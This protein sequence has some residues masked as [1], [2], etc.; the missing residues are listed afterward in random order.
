M[1]HLSVELD[2][3]AELEGIA[4]KG[5]QMTGVKYPH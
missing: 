5:C 3:N 2:W 1:E 4:A